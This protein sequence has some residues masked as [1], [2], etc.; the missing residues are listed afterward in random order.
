M[1]APAGMIPLISG[2]G[3]LSF[4]RVR[5]NRFPDFQRMPLGRWQVAARSAKADSRSPLMDYFRADN[6]WFVSCSNMG[7]LFFKCSSHAP[8]GRISL[9]IDRT[10]CWRTAVLVLLLVQHLPASDLLERPQSR[11]ESIAFA[12]YIASLEQRDPFTEKG[13]VAVLI[14]ASLPH[15]YKD[16]QLLALRRTGENERSEYLILGM[17]GDG[18]A[19]DEVTMRYFALQEEIENLPLSSIQISPENYKFRLRG[20]VK[21]GIGS[22]YV[23]DITPRK[24]RPGLFKGQIWIEAGTGAEVLI[25]GR[26][27]VGP[28]LGS[29]VDFVRETKLDGA[30]YARVTHLS[31]A[32]PLLGRSELVVTERPLGKQDDIEIPQEP[33]KRESSTLSLCTRNNP[34]FPGFLCHVD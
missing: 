12:R 33:S 2:S 17:E 30:S 24:R 32:V 20:E 6:I 25:S 26:L 8:V 22:A 23:Y 11:P 31:V 5:L 28:S 14:E 4:A 18:A 19:L 16:A 27:A 3:P 1:E 7:M 34:T 21:T 15:F 9:F 13:P 29:S 10:C